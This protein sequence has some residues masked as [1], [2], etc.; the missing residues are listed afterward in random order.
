MVVVKSI[1]V[2]LL[3]NVAASEEVCSSSCSSLGMMQTNPG[4][5]CDDI[6][7]INK[8]SRGVSDDY[9]IQTS[10]GVHQVYC[11]MR[12]ECGGHKGGWMR[13]ADLDTSRGDD[14]PGNLIKETINGVDLCHQV[15]ATTRGCFGTNYTVNGVEYTKICG[16]AKGYQKGAPSS[17]SGVSNIEDTYVDGVSITIGHPRKHVWTYAVGYD[18]DRNTPVRNCPCASFSIVVPQTFVGEHYYC[19][20][21]NAVDGSPPRD[22]YY[23]ADPLWDGEGCVGTNNNCCTSVGMPWFL[24]QF[25]TVQHEDVEVRLCQDEGY[26]NNGVAVDLIQLFVK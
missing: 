16:Q 9:W 7:Q 6:Y 18:D 13:I 4:K 23:T 10:T 1:L 12:L 2:I 17:L 26:N 3:A 15:F 25:P 24:R 14:C 21:G 19:E 11:D 20:S 8:A 22:K 5:S